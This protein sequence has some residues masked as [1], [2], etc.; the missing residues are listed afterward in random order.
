MPYPG[1]IYLRRGPVRASEAMSTQKVYATTPAPV[2]PCALLQTEIT[3][4]TRWHAIKALISRDMR[5]R[6][7]DKVSL[8]WLVIRAIP[9][10][11]SSTA[12]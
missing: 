12:E 6:D 7:A 10:S 3:P 9:H 4:E 8:R 1:P 2:S 5:E 11:S